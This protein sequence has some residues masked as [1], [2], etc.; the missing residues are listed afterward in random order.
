MFQEF[1]EALLKFNRPYCTVAGNFNEKEAFVRSWV[2]ND[3]KKPK[4]SYKIK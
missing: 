2:Q 1:E 3:L 4:Q